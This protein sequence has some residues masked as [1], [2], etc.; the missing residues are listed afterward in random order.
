MPSAHDFNF[1]TIDGKPL[2]M[3][4]FAGKPVLVVWGK[5][6]KDV[7]FEVSKEVLR[8]VPQAEFHSIDDAGHVPYYEHPEIVN[9]MLVSFL[10]K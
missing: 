4:S 1:T 5:A 3:K 9:P 7:P 6:D 2:P 10:K 8:A